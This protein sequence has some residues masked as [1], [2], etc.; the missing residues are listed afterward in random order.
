MLWFGLQFH[1][2]P[3]WDSQ[4]GKEVSVNVRNMNNPAPSEGARRASGDGPGPR[5]EPR[6]IFPHG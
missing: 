2:T 3:I 4:E 1:W 6:G 5:P